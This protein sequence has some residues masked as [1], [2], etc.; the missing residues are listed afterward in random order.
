MQFSMSS[1][2]HAPVKEVFTFCT[3]P[4][5]FEQQFPYTVRWLEANST[6]EQGTI[7]TFKFQFL[8]LGLFN[9][10]LYYQAEI[11][12]FELNQYF[13]DVMRVGPYK[14]FRHR[15]DF[16]ATENTTRYTDTIEF[17]LGY[18]ALIDRYIGKPILE[19]HLQ[20]NGIVT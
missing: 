18:G 6:W 16:V 17:S 5:G 4:T 3:S 19:K 14:Y 8:K 13:V 7:V 2:I 9:A 1:Q 11:V 15:H 12:E 10:W 20:N